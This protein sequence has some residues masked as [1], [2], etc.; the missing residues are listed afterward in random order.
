M[1]RPHAGARARAPEGGRA[2]GQRCVRRND[3]GVPALRGQAPRCRGGRIAT[4]YL[5]WSTMKSTA[6]FT[7]ASG[8]EVLP[9]FGG[10]M[11]FLPW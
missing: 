10:I 5:D 8:I 3:N 6:A 2:A 1:I 4:A 7:S 9:P 11:P